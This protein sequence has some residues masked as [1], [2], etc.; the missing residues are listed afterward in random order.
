MRVWTTNK[1][2]CI[3][4]SNFYQKRDED[5]GREFKTTVVAQEKTVEYNDNSLGQGKI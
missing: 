5:E 1:T 4:G 3:W 2:Y